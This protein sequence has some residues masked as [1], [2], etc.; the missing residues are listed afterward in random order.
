MR[1]LTLVAVSY[2]LTNDCCL[3]CCVP[4]WTRGPVSRL[5]A[6][7]MP[8]ETM[9]WLKLPPV[10]KRQTQTAAESPSLISNVQVRAREQCL[11]GLAGREGIFYFA[12]CRLV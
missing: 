1:V 3:K 2:K 11:Q 6:C 10:S 8:Q 4:F 9:E 12:L 7:V 5:T